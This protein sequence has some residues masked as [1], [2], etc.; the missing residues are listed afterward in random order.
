MIMA[1]AQKI[2]VLLLGVACAMCAA[3]SALAADVCVVMSKKIP[4]YQQAF[5]GLAEVVGSVKRFDLDGKREQGTAVMGELLKGD[6]AVVV[7]IGSLALDI[8]RLQVGD[9][10]IIYTMVAAPST[11]VQDTKNIA[12]VTIDPPVERLLDMLKRIVPNA[13]KIGVVTNP[14]RARHF[15]D[16]LTMHART[17][18]MTVE[19]A[20]ATDMKSISAAVRE[21]LPRVD[22]LFMVPD[23][24]TANQQAFEYMLLESLRR[25][26][27][28][29]GLSRKHV[30]AGALFAYSVDYRDVGT[31][32]GHMVQQVMG[33]TPVRNVQRGRRSAAFIINAKSAKQL[34]LH[35]DPSITAEAAEVIR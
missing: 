9:H 29:I 34:G 4:P 32:A 19:L 18:G 8:V 23:P 6:C 33:G 28:L 1:I 24:A 11:A 13:S 20:R 25:G 7:P 10:P 14:V 17:R 26:I 5:D 3:R 15:V 16:A 21:L 22:A 30:S 35:L 2:T 31:T 12:G 27:P